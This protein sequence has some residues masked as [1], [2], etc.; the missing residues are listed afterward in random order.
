MATGDIDLGRVFD[1]LSIMVWMALPDGQI[2]F[3]NRCWSEFIG[4]GLEDIRASKWQAFVHPEDLERLLERWRLIVA[5]GTAGEMEARVGRFDGQYHWINFQCNPIRGTA[6]DILKWCGVATDVEDARRAEEKLRRRRLDLQTIIDSI[7]IPVA[8]TTPS[9]EVE[10]LNQLT[11]DYFGRT[12]DE[13]KGWKSSDVVH[14]DDLERTVAAQLEAHRTSTPYNVESRHRRADN[15]YRWYNV[16]G[17]PLRDSQ[18]EIVRWL[19]LLIDIDDRRRAE[20]AL[21]ESERNSK[22]IVNTISAGFC[23]LSPTGEV[24]A[25]NDQ[26]LEYFGKSKKKLKHWQNADVVHP[27]DRQRITQTIEHSFATGDP[28]DT[29]QRLRGKDGVYRWFRV[30][31]LPIRDTDNRIVRWYVLHIDI[32]EKKRAEQAVATSERNLKAI[33]DTIPVLAW[34]AR[35]DGSAEFFNQ[36]YLDYIGLSDEQA[37]GWGWA[38]TVHPDD[39][40]GLAG[41]WQAILAAGAP[42]EAEARLRRHDGEYRLFLF[43][44][45]PLRDE[46]GTVV[47][48]H[49][50]NIDIED[51]RRSEESFRTIVETTPECVK[52]VA[53]DGTVLR[54]NQAGAIMAGVPSPDVVVGHNFFDFVVPEHRDQ[55]RLFHERVCDGQKGFLE[56]DLV[57]LQGVLRHVETHAAP[58]LGS[59]GSVMQLGVTRDITE[60]KKAEERL[61]RS[62]AFLAEGQQ[63]ARMGNFSWCISAGEIVWSEQLYRIFAFDSKDPVTM[64]LVASRLHPEDL[65]LMA[66]FLERAQYGAHDLDYQLRILM[67]DRSVKYLHLI[68]HLAR[69]HP[70]RLEYTGAV[71]DITQR[72]LA[73]EALSKAQSELAHV[74]RVTSLG[75]LTAS[76]A[77]EI[78]Q[79][80]SG[81][82]TNA[83]TC[84]R[85]LSA[86]PPNIAMAQETARRTMRDGNRAAE[87]IARL[88]SLFSKKTVEIEP[89]DLN[90]VAREVIA[91]AKNDLQRDKVVLHTELANGIRPVGGDRVQL[92]QVIMNLLRN[93]SDAMASVVDRPRRLLVRTEPADND[94]V[95]L[96]VQ[97]AGVGFGPEGTTR[98]FETF[99]TTKSDGMGIGLS[100]SRSIVESLGGRLWAE[101]NA[102]PGATFSFS[103]P[104]YSGDGVQDN[105]AILPSVRNGRGSMELRASHH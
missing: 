45:N 64:E 48:W 71:M 53:R 52:V 28:F 96:M 8:V 76:I 80:L 63:L 74:T 95:K 81:I 70:G 57:S 4:L 19:H 29:E 56:F 88:R 3:V 90:E 55:Y 98:L 15:V 7:P 60:R 78:N 1:A 36:H 85:M 103:I 65:P 79:P 84:L 38:A 91:L 35:P 51:R 100:I 101:A 39:M 44:A 37:Q 14:P 23:V 22:L 72:R 94:Q 24:E 87:M 13:L 18:G 83:S 61:R 99:Y 82:V 40:P 25:L 50:V 41:T 62:Q 58:M 34:S 16:L 77:H 17:L 43:R 27:D 68:A 6:G 86:A 73:E 59:D 12:L 30:R 26:L 5:S 9:G 67:P 102:G 69:D 31:G 89:V 46:H 32:D 42:G 2:D 54:T 104:E 47:K 10:G 33:V 11:L 92:Q 75:V 93:A 20:D 97:D 105:F 49:G 21:R 66:D